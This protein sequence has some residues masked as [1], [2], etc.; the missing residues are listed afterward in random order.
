MCHF[1]SPPPLVLRTALRCV[2]GLACCGHFVSAGLRCVVSVA[3]CLPSPHCSQG[4][5]MLCGACV[6]PSFRLSAVHYVDGYILFCLSIS[7][8]IGGL[9]LMLVSRL[10]FPS[11]LVDSCL[12]PSHLTLTWSSL[13]C[14]QHLAVL[15]D[16]TLKTGVHLAAGC[17]A[18]SEVPCRSD[19]GLPEGLRW[20]WQR[21]L[22]SWGWWSAPGVHCEPLLP[23]CLESLGQEPHGPITRGCRNCF[24]FLFIYFF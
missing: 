23:L 6:S 16:L 18:L 20:K 14:R 2:C 11:W 22:C 13:E 24:Y 21:P 3:D 5:L 1:P 10:F 9:F 12:N 4:S 8:W 19:P 15:R 17:V 7:W